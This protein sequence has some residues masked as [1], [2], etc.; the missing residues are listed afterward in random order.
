MAVR[1][2]PVHAVEAGWALLECHDGSMPL[3]DDD[4]PRQ[5]ALDVFVLGD[6]DDFRRPGSWYAV[7]RP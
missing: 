1:A 6:S 3:M 7:P 2:T 4:D 5:V